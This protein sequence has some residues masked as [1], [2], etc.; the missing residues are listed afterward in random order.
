MEQVILLLQLTLGVGW[1][2]AAG[3][4][5][6]GCVKL[7][8]ND[9]NDVEWRLHVMSVMSAAGASLT[10]AGFAFPVAYWGVDLVVAPESAKTVKVAVYT[11]CAVFSAWRLFNAW[12]R[13]GG[14]PTPPSGAVERV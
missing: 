3:F 2:I 14:S 11:V 5:V 6:W 10:V 12:K 13:L 4:V 9:G 1:L 7:A 8:S